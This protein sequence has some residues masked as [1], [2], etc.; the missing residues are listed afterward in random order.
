MKP[1]LRAVVTHFLALL[2]GI[3]FVFVYPFSL[4]DENVTID[5]IY[6]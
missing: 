3:S 2:V 4:S 5:V 6:S 1:V